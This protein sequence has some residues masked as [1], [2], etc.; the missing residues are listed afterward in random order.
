VWKRRRERFSVWPI[1]EAKIGMVRDHPLSA[2]RLAYGV[3][4]P[5]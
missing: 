4:L 1:D 2:Q 3:E 5:P